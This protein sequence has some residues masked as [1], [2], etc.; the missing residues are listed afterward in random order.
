VW[1]GSSEG[2][3]VVGVAFLDAAK[4]WVRLACNKTSMSRAQPDPAVRG[5]ACLM[6]LPGMGQQSWLLGGA[7]HVPG[8]A[9]TS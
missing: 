5:R 8:V 3:R 2:Q 9:H 1:L 6:W 7:E 4:R